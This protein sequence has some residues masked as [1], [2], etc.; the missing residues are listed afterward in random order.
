MYQTKFQKK[1]KKTGKLILKSN[2]YN[3]I[4]FWASKQIIIVIINCCNLIKNVC[5]KKLFFEMKTFGDRKRDRETMNFRT[6][7]GKTKI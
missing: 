4:A 7:H 6:M 1:I 3:N 5:K 2:F